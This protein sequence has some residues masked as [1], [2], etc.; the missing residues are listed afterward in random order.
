MSW[1]KGQR[2]FITIRGNLGI[3][4]AD[5]LSFKLLSFSTQKS[6][7]LSQRVLHFPSFRD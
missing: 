5:Y 6:A 3:N 4:Q 2:I 1:E 7:L